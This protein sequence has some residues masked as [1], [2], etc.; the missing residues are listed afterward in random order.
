[1]QVADKK[2]YQEEGTPFFPNHLLKEVIVMYLL[3]GI[4]ISLAI[5]VP[6]ELHGKADPLSTPEGI[7]PE[8]YFLA[9]YQLLKYFPQY[10]LSISGK[11]LCIVL[12]GICV[13]ILLLLPFTDRNP[14]RHP[15]KRPFA[16]SLFLLVVIFA[17][18]LTALAHLSDRRLTFFG[19]TYQFDIKGIPHRIGK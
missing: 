7:K 13:L 3:L 5:I 2:N 8:W 4:V 6:F 11:S 12:L 1:M 18:I 16:M 14:Q 10:V 15:Q 17:I 9:V 19:G